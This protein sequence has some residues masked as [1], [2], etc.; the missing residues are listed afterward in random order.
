MQK[1]K[2]I[3]IPTRKVGS[4][5]RLINDFIVS[6]DYVLIDV[7]FNHVNMGG[8]DKTFVSVFYNEG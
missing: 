2:V 5:D 7:K 3:E 8:I 6:N 1:L 4:V